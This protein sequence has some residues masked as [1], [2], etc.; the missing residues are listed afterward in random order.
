MIENIAAM[1]VRFITKRF[2]GE[3]DSRERLYNFSTAIDNEV[4]NFEILDSMGLNNQV[5]SYIK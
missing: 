4:V 1:I 2:I 3:Y 5:F